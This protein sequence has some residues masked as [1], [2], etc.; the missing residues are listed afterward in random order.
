MKEPRNAKAQV[1]ADTA[2]GKAQVFAAA[3]DLERL[4][5]GPESDRLAIADAITAH[6]R[7]KGLDA[8]GQPVLSPTPVAPAV[9]YRKQESI[10]DQ[11]RAAMRAHKLEELEQLEESLDEADDFEISDDPPDPGSK[12]ETGTLPSLQEIRAMIEQHKARLPEESTAPEAP[13]D[14]QGARGAAPAGKSKSSA[15]PTPPDL[16]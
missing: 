1:F 11:V 16:D 13:K 5:S 6:R 4:V 2:G 10:F 12:Y 3:D 14:D 7:R 9:G 8:D 15:T